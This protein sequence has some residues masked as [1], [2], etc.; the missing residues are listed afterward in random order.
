MSVLNK[1]WQVSPK[2]PKEFIQEYPEFS[3]VILQLLY[4]RGINAQNKID[5]FFN[6]DYQ[7]DIFNPMLLKGMDRAL[8]R[9]LKAY[10][11]NER[12]AIFG[13]YDADGVTSSVLLMELFRDILGLKGQVY[14]PDRL[15]EGYGMNKAA[16]DWL[17]KKN[18]KLIITCD[19]GVSNKA[20]IDYARNL[21]IDVIVTDHH[22][23]PHEFSHDYIVINPKQ[24]G[25]QYPFKELAGVGVAY[26]LAQA[27]INNIKS[28][29]SVKTD[30]V[31]EKNFLDLVA[32]GTIAD[33]SP[34]ISEN[35]A[36][37]KYGIEVLKYNSRKGL[38][39]LFDIAGLDKT[40]INTYAIG[41][42][43]A[44]RIN[45]AG[46][47][48][49]ANTAYKLLATNKDQEAQALAKKINE[50]NITRQKLT[51]EISIKAKNVIGDISKKNKIL[52]AVG[53][54]WPLGVLGIVA[55]KIS[56]EY[57][58]PVMIAGQGKDQTVGSARGIDAFNLIEAIAKNKAILLEYGGHKKAA[59]FTVANNN[60]NKFFANMI[61]I[62][63]N[64]IKDEDLT[65]ITKID[66]E[67]DVNQ[68]NWDL[69]NE[70]I[71]FEPFGINN[72]R[73]LFKFTNVRFEAI[74][75]LGKE[76]KHFKIEIVNNVNNL[77][78]ICFNFKNNLNNLKEGDIIDFIAE[79]NQNQWN[80]Y[81]KMQLIV[82]DIRIKKL[83]E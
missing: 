3:Y 39:T 72:E 11:F 57:N 80:G 71:K 25:D 6:P 27:I 24:K 7:Q 5:E 63:G 20:E 59:G 44:P 28:F 51:E 70:L 81:K 14:I 66:M 47:L 67:L 13:D 37:V 73:P 17:N 74:S 56:E 33:C 48:D 1:K 32:I 29:K 23:L 41:F 65:P 42:V 15:T 12:V 38:Q 61:E 43:I 79:I 82:K 8:E 64:D 34:I 9:I 54:D 36:L 2:A 77:E 16:V 78:V 68:V 60:L 4:N 35:R 49:H 31:F 40:K 76:K 10:K 62:A 46:R 55:G 58:R 18:I 52:I 21:G 83:H 22:S 69:Y 19:C 53:D 50:S 45:S 26:K 30:S 75:A